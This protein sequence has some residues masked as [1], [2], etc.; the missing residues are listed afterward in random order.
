[1]YSRAKLK[2]KRGRDEIFA[3]LKRRFYNKFGGHCFE[4]LSKVSGHFANKTP[5]QSHE[6]LRH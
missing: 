1:M 6:R 2:K 3:K 5:M 4:G